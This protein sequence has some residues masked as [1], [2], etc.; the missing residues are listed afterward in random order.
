MDRAVHAEDGSEQGGADLQG[1]GLAGED[2]PG[3]QR[4][5]VLG[6]DE[7][8]GMGG[9]PRDEVQRHRCWMP[10]EIVE[11]NEAEAAAGELERA[12]STMACSCASSTSAA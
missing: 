11:V 4:G 3:G 6:D 1:I 8:G 12:R 10:A 9:L 5:R 7:T 2:H